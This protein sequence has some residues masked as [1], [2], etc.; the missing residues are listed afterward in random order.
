MR[1]ILVLSVAT[2][3][4]AIMVITAMVVHA[5]A[6]DGEDPL[7]VWYRSLKTDIGG[8]CCT[9]ADCGPVDDYAPSAVPGGYLA[10]FRGRWLEVPPSKV[11]PRSDN[12]TGK[13]VLCGRELQILC[14]VLPSQG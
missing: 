6:H 13:A 12:P 7:A 14:F 10:K 2:L 3:A 9:A 8:S 11:L 4:G 1:L 5:S